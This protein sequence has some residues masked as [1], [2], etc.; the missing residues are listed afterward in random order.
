GARAQRPPGQGPGARLGRTG[1]EGASWY[2]HFRGLLGDDQVTGVHHLHVAVDL[3][4]TGLGRGEVHRGDFSGVCY[5][6]RSEPAD[7]YE[8]PSAGVGALDAQVE[9]HWYALLH[10]DG[11]G[12]VAA[13]VA[14]HDDVE[15]LP[16]VGGEA[17]GH[18]LRL[19]F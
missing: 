18:G 3:E 1:L 6:M 7:R 11:V 8:A 19:E 14:V 12:L 9:V 17:S 10:L 15:G 2:G 5:A 13:A 16:T 4:N